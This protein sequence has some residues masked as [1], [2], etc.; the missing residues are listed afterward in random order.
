MTIPGLE[1]LQQRI[2][3]AAGWHLGFHVAPAGIPAPGPPFLQFGSDDYDGEIRATLPSGLDGGVYTFTVAGLIP[4]HYTPLAAVLNTPS[5]RPDLVVKLYLFWRDSSGIGGYLGSLSG[6]GDALDRPTAETLGDSLVA[7]LTVQ[8]IAQ[9]VGTRRYETTIVARESVYDRLQRRLREAVVLPV[10]QALTA[11]LTVY[12]N[13]TDFTNHGFGTTTESPPTGPAQPPPNLVLRKG[14]TITDALAHI[15]AR[16]EEETG[17]YG[18]GLFLIRDGRLE[19]GVRRFP[20]QGTAKDL[21]VA[22]GLV[23]VESLG[24]VQTDPH[25][26]AHHPEGSAPER[27]QFKLTLRGRSDLKPGDVVRFGSPPEE[28]VAPAGFG[29]AGIVGDLLS[30]PLLP[31]LG[32][33][34]EDPIRL[35]VTSVEH[36]LGRSSSFVT[37]VTGVEAAEGQ[38]WD[39]H[40]APVPD[41]QSS[42]GPQAAGD[43]LA[44]GAVRQTAR[45]EA[46]A[47][48]LTEVGEVRAMTSASSGPA[49]SQTLEVWRGLD[50]ADGQPNQS[51]RLPILRPTGAPAPD[52]P[53]ATPFAWGKCGLVLPRYP[54]TRVVVTHRDGR[55]DEAIDIGAIWESGHGPD[56][57]PGDWW[58][59]LPVGLQ[60]QSDRASLTREAQPQEHGGVA[61]NDLIDAEGNRV[62]E[63]GELTIRVG[64]DQL[65]NAGTRP[66]RGLEDGITI[67]HA[68][69]GAKIVMHP[70][71]MIELEAKKNLELR[72]PDGDIVLQA[73]NVKAQVDTA[74]EVS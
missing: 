61:T 59:I 54:G 40:S 37:T 22:A 58:L 52:I 70:D 14:T 4:D 24:P 10:D 17:R 33:E 30:S 19:V 6:L 31:S 41:P 8:S 21:T 65:Q 9:K 64:R 13:F 69:T 20:L 63:L 16:K 15:G 60:P 42:R 66:A 26:Y 46:A 36:R 1:L 11:A 73:K 62:I 45:D 72:A 7:V 47:R 51:R 74:M 67:E 55:P 71:G 44:A 38:E 48:V 57:D 35:Y 27:R 34:L 3:N 49:V 2:G 18:R 50:G 5:P 56:S 53:Y 29:V 32:A 43:T 23:E 68:A 39:S 25:Y 28:S 12:G